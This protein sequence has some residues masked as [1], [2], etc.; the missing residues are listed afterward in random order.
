MTTGCYPSYPSLEQFYDW[1]SGRHSRGVRL[2]R[3][4]LGRRN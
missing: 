1:R 2:R 4:Q 3:V